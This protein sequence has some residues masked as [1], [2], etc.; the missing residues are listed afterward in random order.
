MQGR[1][2]VV[3]AEANDLKTF[4]SVLPSNV[5]QVW[6]HLSTWST[7]ACA[8]EVGQ[9]CVAMVWRQALRNM[10]WEIPDLTSGI[11]AA[12]QS[13]TGQRETVATD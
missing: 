8:T 6:S 11:S 1:R 13:I 2:K 10:Q 5:G 12:L 4:V 3:K 7:P 9:G